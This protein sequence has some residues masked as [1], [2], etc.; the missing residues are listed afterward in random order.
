MGSCHARVLKCRVYVSKRYSRCNP[1]RLSIG[2]PGQRGCSM[3]LLLLVCVAAHQDVM[4]Q[5]SPRDA[6]TA[7]TALL[8]VLAAL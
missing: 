1:G 8:L 3:H 5:R 2:S 7:P 6:L 4:L